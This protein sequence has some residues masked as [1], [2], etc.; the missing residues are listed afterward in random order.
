[1]SQFEIVSDFGMTGDRPQAVASLPPSSD[2]SLED[3]IK[4]ALGYFGSK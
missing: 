3:K 1:M 2:L 4:L